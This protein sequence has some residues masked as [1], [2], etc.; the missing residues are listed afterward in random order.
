MNYKTVVA[1]I[2]LASVIIACQTDN[3]G[4]TKMYLKETFDSRWS[5]AEQF[6][7]QNGQLSSYKSLLGDRVVTLT[8]FTYRNGQLKHIQIN[9][10]NGIGYLI[11]LDY[12]ANGLRSR[13]R[14]T[15]SENGQAMRV[16]TI[17]FIYN[18]KG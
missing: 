13:E 12:H 17:E 16:T 2:F 3:V 6:E 1:G 15:Y 9:H 5:W 7:Y 11:E 18:E 10:D 4:P 8:N 14:K